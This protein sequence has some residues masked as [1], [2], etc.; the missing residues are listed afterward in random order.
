MRAIG[1]SL[2]PEDDDVAVGR[3]LWEQRQHRRQLLEYSDSESEPSIASFRR[4][5]VESRARKENERELESVSHAVNQLERRV[6]YCTVMG[7]QF[8]EVMEECDRRRQQGESE[9]GDD[10]AEDDDD[11][12]QGSD[13]YSYG[14]TSME[15]HL[16]LI[17]EKIRD[18][19]RAL[20]AEKVMEPTSHIQTAEQ[21]EPAVC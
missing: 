9:D 2:R 10:E 20:V 1:M 12:D 4:I 16:R 11:D 15:E 14:L 13:A 5:A 8:E 18:A 7:P 3:R 19:K 17:D 21:V 6:F